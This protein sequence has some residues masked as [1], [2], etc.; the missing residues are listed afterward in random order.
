MRYLFKLIRSLV[1]GISLCLGGC[2]STSHGIDSSP[3]VQAFINEMAAK[4][5]FNRTDLEQLFARVEYQPR[6]IQ[7]M[8]AP[9]EAKPW[10]I[11]RNTFLTDAR[12]KAGVKFWQAHEQQLAQV[13]QEYGVPASVIVAIL[14]VETYYGAMQGNYRVIDALSTLAFQY[15]PRAAFFKSELAHY[16]LM[17]RDAHI[18]P[19]SILGSYA[20]AFGKTQFMPSSYR[21]YAVAYQH[22]GYSDL[23]NND[24]DVIASIANYFKR[25]GW[26]RGETIAEPAIVMSAQAA[27][28]ASQNMQ[29]ARTIAAWQQLGVKPAKPLPLSANAAL[30][31]LQQKQGAE[32]WLGLHNFYVL[33]RYNPRLNYAM[34]VYQLSLNILQLRQQLNPQ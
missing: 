10:Y 8:T 6:I 19:E 28:L 17:T 4:Y 9:H 29:P 5:Q 3:A 13:E 23:A 20:G 14:G 24:G 26:R 30:L 16:L 25:N 31:L 15:P 12:A 32:Y 27:R 22:E 1:F 7:L 34:A 18:N 33:S 11:Y 2:A 21:N